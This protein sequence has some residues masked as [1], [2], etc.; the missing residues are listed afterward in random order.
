MKIITL[1]LN[2]AF[3]IHCTAERFEAH[4]ENLVKIIS[5]DAGGK[6]VNIGRALAAYGIDAENFV[7]L[8][9]DNGQEFAQL[10]YN[11]GLKL[12]TLSVAGRIRENMTVSAPTSPETRISFS[13]FSADDS[14]LSEVLSALSPMLSDECIVTFSGRLP[15]GISH[16]AAMAFLCALKSKGAR[17]VL[18]THA[19]GREDIIALSPWLI[20]PNEEELSRYLGKCDSVEEIIRA[21]GELCSRGVENVLVSLGAHG[22]VLARGEG[23]YLVDAPEVQVSSTVGAGD[24]SIAGFISAY[25]D[26]EDGEGMLKRAVA[27]G[28]AA[29]MTFGT[30]AP[31][32]ESINELLSKM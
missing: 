3:D 11:E 16:E 31:T 13:G 14:L 25:L 32:K 22:A 7:V 29:C 30:T 8:A 4:R 27:F 5:R 28:S 2:P 12:R 15:D 10:L 26:G 20:K 19:L 21:A 18:D 23:C 17:L 24:S 6:G 9:E 1:T